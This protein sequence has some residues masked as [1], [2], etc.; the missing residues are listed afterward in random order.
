MNVF[1]VPPFIL[2]VRK[3]SN[4]DRPRVWLAA[5]WALDRTLACLTMTL[6][7]SKS[8]VRVLCFNVSLL[9]YWSTSPY[10]PNRGKRLRAHPLIYKDTFNRC[11]DMG[12]R[13]GLVTFSTPC[14]I[15]QHHVYLTTVVLFL[16]SCRR[17][18]YKRKY[19]L[20]TNPAK[21]R[22]CQNAGN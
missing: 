13:E 14:S 17:H 1:G 10:K 5:L 22:R 6:R 8:I 3:N 12:A 15:L 21:Q 4:S 20:E 11:N 18:V 16:V 19:M 2:Y 9:S 7:A